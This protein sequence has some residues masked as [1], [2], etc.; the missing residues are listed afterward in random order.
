MIGEIA[1]S[2]R[3]GEALSGPAVGYATVYGTELVLLFFTLIA[4]A[5]LVSRRTPQPERRDK[6]KIGLAEFPT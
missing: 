4:L 3:L 2:G 1:A 5:P 6:A